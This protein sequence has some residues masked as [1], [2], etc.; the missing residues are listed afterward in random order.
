MSAMMSQSDEQQVVFWIDG[1]YRK[2]N[3][4][5]DESAFDAAKAE[6]L[7]N[8]QR[9]LENIGLMTFERWKEVRGSG[10]KND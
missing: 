10:G 5:T 1:Y 3:A 2:H 7:Q 4:E 6:L 9:H 8:M